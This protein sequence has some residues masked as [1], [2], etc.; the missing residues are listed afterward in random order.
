MAFFDEAERTR[1]EA[2]IELT[3]QHT[4]GELV[5][6]TVRASDGYHGVRALYGFACGLALAAAI[7]VVRPTLG[8]ALLAWLEVGMAALTWLA[9]GWGPALRLLLPKAH[10]RH[11]VERRAREEFFERALFATRGRTGVLIFLSELERQVAILGDAGIHERVQTDGW[12]AHVEHIIAQIR[13]GR[14]A[15]GVCE[16]IAKLGVSLEGVV[17]RQPDDRNE[18][19]NTVREEER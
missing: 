13:A 19:P 1:I 18:L 10:A 4:A 12:Q 2:A 17:P 6:A 3:E 8:F 14:A 16:V 15:A 9:L 11:A 7:H 5:V